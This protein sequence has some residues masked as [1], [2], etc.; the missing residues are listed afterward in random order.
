MGA[1]KSSRA[2]P[3]S[4]ISA[5]AAVE[6]NMAVK[7]GRRSEFFTTCVFAQSTSCQGSRSRWRTAKIFWKI[8]IDIPGCVASKP[9][10]VRVQLMFY[11]L[12]GEAVN[13]RTTWT[14]SVQPSLA[15]IWFQTM[16]FSVFWVPAM[17]RL[18]QTCSSKLSTTSLDKQAVLVLLGIFHSSNH[19]LW[20]SPAAHVTLAC[21]TASPWPGRLTIWN[22]VSMAG[23]SSLTIV[24]PWNSAVARCQKLRLWTM[25][26]SFLMVF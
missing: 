19:L 5:W 24:R 2:W 23:W 26:I 16:S 25:S 7:T 9:C 4:L 3:L 10:P 17:H 12:T 14:R 18:E 13:G 21:F 1:W 22:V 8:L 15:S 6:G 20:G 11:Q